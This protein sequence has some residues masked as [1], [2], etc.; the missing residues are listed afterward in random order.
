MIIVHS[1]YSYSQ[2]GKD[3]FY[4]IRKSINKIIVELSFLFLNKS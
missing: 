4:S 1:H 3:K 2:T